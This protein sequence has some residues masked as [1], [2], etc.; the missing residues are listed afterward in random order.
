MGILDVLKAQ[1]IQRIEPTTG[2]QDLSGTNVTFA[3]SVT[4]QTPDPDIGNMVDSKFMWRQ[5]MIDQSVP[6]QEFFTTEFLLA[7]ILDTLRKEQ[8]TAVPGDYTRIINLNVPAQATPIRNQQ[9]IFDI[10]PFGHIFIP[11]NAGSTITSYKLYKGIGTSD[12]IC[13]ANYT[14]TPR[15][16][17]LPNVDVVTVLF[18][19][20]ILTATSFQVWLSVRPITVI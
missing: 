16:I 18:D 4:D 17:K 1:E 14:T 8:Q 9:Q 15:S 13:S 6:S 12:L 20:D 5:T 10:G 2:R 19:S 7:Q 11:N 3:P